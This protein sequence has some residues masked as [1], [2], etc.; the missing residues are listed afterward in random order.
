MVRCN[1]CLSVT[2]GTFFFFY[3]S[4]CFDYGLLLFV[5]IIFECVVDNGESSSRVASKYIY[6][7]GM[8]NGSLA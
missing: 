1:Q 7:Y 2:V 4:S 8:V 3:S 6:V 5:V